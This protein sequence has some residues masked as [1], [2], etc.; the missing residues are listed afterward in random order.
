[1]SN[2]TTMVRREIGILMV[3]TGVAYFVSESIK[4]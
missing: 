3:A 1:M 4:E 2:L